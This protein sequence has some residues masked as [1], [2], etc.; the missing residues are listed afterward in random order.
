MFVKLTQ[1]EDEADDVVRRVVPGEP[2]GDEER[3]APPE[4]RPGRLRVDLRQPTTMSCVY[5]HESTGLQGLESLE[6]EIAVVT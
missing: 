1:C 3:L 4:Y 6:R 2:D 5:L